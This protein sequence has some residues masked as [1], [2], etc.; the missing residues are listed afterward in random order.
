MLNNVFTATLTRKAVPLEP[1][2]A[3]F[4]KR[5]GLNPRNRHIE[6]V[7]GNCHA[8]ISENYLT[9]LLRDGHL[10]D[11]VNTALFYTEQRTARIE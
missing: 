11:E 9:S 2:E 7:Q 3:I 8:K 5:A 6:P 10:C 4:P 1:H